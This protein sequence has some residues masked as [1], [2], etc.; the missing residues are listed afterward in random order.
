MKH[1]DYE[2]PIEIC[3]PKMSTSHI[4]TIFPFGEFS[5]EY[6]ALPLV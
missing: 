4:Y 6:T 1:A 3:L 2:R 5:H